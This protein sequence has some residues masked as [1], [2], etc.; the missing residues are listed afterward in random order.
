MVGPAPDWGADEF[1]HAGTESGGSVYDLIVDL[2]GCY[3]E[4]H[5][6]EQ[7][8]IC[9]LDRGLKMKFSN[10]DSSITIGHS[11]PSGSPLLQPH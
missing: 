7:M 5:F 8:L 6:A 4:R 11:N 1:A 2:D 3:L 10:L 9:G